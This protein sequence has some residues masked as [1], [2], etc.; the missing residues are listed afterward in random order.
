M[1][2]V[3]NFNIFFIF[4]IFPQ[5]G[6]YPLVAGVGSTYSENKFSRLL[7]KNLIL[8]YKMIWLNKKEQRRFKRDE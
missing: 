5:G 3:A 4:F 1:H 6:P 2:N 7:E 8:G